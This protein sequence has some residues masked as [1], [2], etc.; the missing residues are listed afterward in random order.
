MDYFYHL[1]I[2]LIQGFQAI[3]SWLTIPMKFFTSL[4]FEEFYLVIM[5]AIYWCIDSALGLRIGTML[6][7]SNGVNSFFK[8]A[9]HSPRPY[10][11]DPGVRPLASETSFGIPSGH[12]Q[13]AASV[14][15]L[16]AASI[17]KRWATGLVVFF[18]LMIGLSRIY[19][20]VHFVSDVLA[21][22]LIGA[23]LLV[24]YLRLEPAVSAKLQ[25][26]SFKGL[27][28]FS[29]G[30]TLV[31]LAIMGLPILA[32]GSWQAPAQWQANAL[33]ALPDV[34]FEPLSPTGAFTLS[35]LWLGLTLGAAWIYRRTD[36]FRVQGSFI[37]RA[38]RYGLGM[39]GT[40]LLWL[41]LK[42]IFPE[43][44]TV[45]GYSLRF[46]RYAI[47]G[48]WVTALAPLLFLKLKLAESNSKPV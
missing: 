12:A 17:K 44:D 10:W 30:S 31:I 6:V 18:V 2:L 42:Q 13:N 29:I 33:A 21:G 36:G 15:G 8:V 37:Q 28:L 22:W 41:G 35:G 19:L 14:W 46:V 27:V 32:L 1:Q 20:A 7:L 25:I 3:G 39:A 45:L 5:P 26:T 16:M 48:T 43:A 4:G 9:L 34:P 47:V 24:L 11:Y 23:L 38:L 40:V